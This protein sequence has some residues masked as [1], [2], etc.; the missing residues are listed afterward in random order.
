MFT[1]LISESGG[2]ELANNLEIARLTNTGGNNAWWSRSWLS[3]GLHTAM[4]AA[5]GR[6]GSRGAYRFL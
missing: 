5:V 4:E 1:A 3:S 2:I 6:Y